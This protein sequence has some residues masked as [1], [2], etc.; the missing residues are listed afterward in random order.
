M[1][2]EAIKEY[3]LSRDEVFMYFRKVSFKALMQFF[4]ITLVT[5]E[6]INGSDGIYTMP[7]TLWIATARFFCAMLLHMHSNPLIEQAYDMLRYLNNN[8]NKFKY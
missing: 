2:H 3:D 1:T 4:F 6:N 5:I 7:T 8:P